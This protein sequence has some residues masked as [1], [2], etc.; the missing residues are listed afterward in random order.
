MARLY[1]M[2]KMARI[3]LVLL[4][5][6]LAMGAQKP[7]GGTRK[8]SSS[9]AP[10]TSQAARQFPLDSIAVEGNK[11]LDAN[12]IVTASGLK[13][14]DRV[15]KT[16]FDAARDR[17]IATG[18]FDTVGYRYKPS[19]Q[20]KG[21]SLTFEVQEMQP[22]FPLR[23]EALPATTQ[24]ITS[25][26]KTK[27]PLFPGKLPGTQQVL[28]RT[29]REIEQYLGSKNHPEKLIGK[30]VATAPDVFEI[31]FQP[32]RGLS[33]VADVTF[34]GNKAVTSTILHNA[35]A[36]VAF[37]QP[38]TE[39][40]FRQLLD[41]QIRP[42]YESKGYLRV[43][44]PKITTAASERVKGVDVKV[45]VDEGTEYKLTR[46]AVAGDMAN[47]SSSILKAA[48]IPQMTIADF[49]QIKQATVRVKEH[50]Q[51]LGYLHA[52]V[53]TERKVD[54]TKKSV[55]VFLVVE[56]GPRYT[57]GNLTITGLGLD[58]EAAIRKMWG[59]KPGE[60]FPKDYPGYFLN[61]VREQGLF[62]NL[63]DTNTKTDVHEDTHVV[64]VALNFKGAPKQ[65][66]KPRVP[67]AVEGQSGPPF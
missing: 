25:F 51:H 13:P 19:E 40:G 46:V 1:N 61:Q 49:D 48:K 33:A 24:E 21:Y 63:G 44:F 3:S 2:G 27:H 66:K 17:L 16:Q 34:E 39:T 45:T 60:P 62:D 42:I 28:D 29:A 47:E 20:G 14:G 37:G 36:D 54:D 5:F 12:N 22:L 57:F 50:M 52:E 58:A 56:P 31:Q 7:P 18:Y 26:L 23:F 15:D 55:E 11:I 9:Q 6:A 8:G 41:N 53:N 43:A 65:Q 32:A 30:V 38:F 4:V 35:I 64:D 10:S 67:G 59:L